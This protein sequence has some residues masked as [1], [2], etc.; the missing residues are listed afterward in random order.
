MKKSLADILKI[1]K[2]R[3]KYKV[4]KEIAERWSPRYFSRGKISKSHLKIIFEAARWAPSGHNRQPWYFYY[5]K[6]GTNAYKNLFSTLN[7]YNQ[8]WAK[9]APLLILACVIKDNNPFAFYDLGAAVISLVLQAQSL[10]Y[11][12]RQMGLF[13][14]QKVKKIFQLEKNLEP[15]IIIAMGKIGDYKTAP[16]EIVKMEIDPRPR[17]KDLFKELL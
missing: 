7:E 5:A 17:K 12:S 3:P 13:D 10:G 8:S 2:P 9:T 6:K 11:Y 4:L 14:K 16:P 1:R 15:Y